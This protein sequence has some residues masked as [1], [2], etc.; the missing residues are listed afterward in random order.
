MNDF[1]LEANFLQQ[2]EPVC[3]GK[4]PADVY[5]MLDLRSPLLFP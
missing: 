2:L 5:V 1:G 3:T 4:E